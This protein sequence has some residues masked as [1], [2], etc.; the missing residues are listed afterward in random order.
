MRRSALCTLLLVLCCSWLVRAQ[1]KPDFGGTW[2]AVS[3]PQFL[4][5]YVTAEVEIETTIK[6]SNLM[7]SLT[8]RIVS[9]ATGKPSRPD[10]APTILY[11]DG[12]ERRSK[13]A[14]G[15]VEVARTFWDGQV[16]VTTAIRKAKDGRTIS[17]STRK[18][19]IRPD[20]LLVIEALLDDGNSQQPARDSMVLKR[21]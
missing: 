15:T 12:Q 6:Q 14:D 21:K 10:L 8:P 13:R 5:R 20:G 7:V 16:L 2:V 11:L 9:K 3:P 18:W 4:K 19:S 1:P 17:T